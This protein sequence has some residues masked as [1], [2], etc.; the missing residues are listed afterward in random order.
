MEGPKHKLHLRDLRQLL[1]P[2]PQAR[3]QLEKERAERLAAA[4]TTDI[5]AE[6]ESEEDEEGEEEEDSENEEGGE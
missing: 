4:E 6:E 3:A 1:R 2:D 5:L